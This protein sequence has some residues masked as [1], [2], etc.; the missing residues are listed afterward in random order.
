M[1]GVHPAFYAVGTRGSFPPLPQYAFIQYERSIYLVM[2]RP[3]HYKED[4]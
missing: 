1:S 3:E 4:S 2:W